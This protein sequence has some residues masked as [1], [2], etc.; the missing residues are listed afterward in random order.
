MVFICWFIQHE[1]RWCWLAWATFEAFILNYSI[2]SEEDLTFTFSFFCQSRGRW[3]ICPFLR[4]LSSPIDGRNT[5][6]WLTLSTT[7]LSNVKLIKVL[8][9][10]SWSSKRGVTR[11]HGLPKNQ[12]TQRILWPQAWVAWLG[13]SFASREA[14]RSKRETA[15]K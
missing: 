4:L 7:L 9:R 3:E 1:R 12:R 13:Q 5:N 2:F 14:I 10:Q 6:P 15:G 11:K 8:S